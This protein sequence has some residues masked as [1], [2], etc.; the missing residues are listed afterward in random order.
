MLRLHMINEL[1]IIIYFF[2][3]NRTNLQYTIYFS[4]TVKICSLCITGINITCNI[5]NDFKFPDNMRHYDL[6]IPKMREKF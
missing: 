5:I 4:I 1:S 2:F 3:D 6:R